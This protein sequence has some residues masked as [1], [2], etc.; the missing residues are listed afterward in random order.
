MNEAELVAA[1]QGYIG[2]T[3]QLFFGYVSLL[4]G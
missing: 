3:N 4:S 2:L 1:F